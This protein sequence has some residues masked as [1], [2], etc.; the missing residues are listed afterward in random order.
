M[1][2]EWLTTHFYQFANYLC[3]DDL[4]ASEIILET[5]NALA[6]TE[7]EVLKNYKM[8]NNEIVIFKK[9]L[10]KAHIRLKNTVMG[11]HNISL[12]SKAVF[13]LMNCLDYEAEECAFIVSRPVTEVLKM[14]ARLKYEYF[15]KKKAANE[16]PNR[17]GYGSIN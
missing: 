16:M 4:H 3:E 12:S 8:R 11:Y 15:E 1:K 10:E 5:A 9:I 6:L 14:N 13:F 2:L 17:V 7:A